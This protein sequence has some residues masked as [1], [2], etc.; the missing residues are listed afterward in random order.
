MT[1]ENVGG[2]EVSGEVSG[3]TQEVNEASQETVSAEEIP[4]DVVEGELQVSEGEDS[5]E[6]EVS[7]PELYTITV[8][9]EQIQVT[10]DEL[11]K[12]LEEFP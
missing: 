7:E 6:E 4:S 8:D 11:L 3:S 12:N 9:G 1:T 2:G 10:L 5:T